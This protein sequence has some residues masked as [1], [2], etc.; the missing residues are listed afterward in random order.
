MRCR[1]SAAP[2]NAI[3][4]PIDAASHRV[5]GD[6]LSPFRLL[7]SEHPENAGEASYAFAHRVRL[8]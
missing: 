4:L 5:E 1:L 3:A 6:G 7:A 2:D 8:V